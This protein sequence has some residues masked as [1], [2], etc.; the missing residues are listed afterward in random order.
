MKKIKVTLLIVLLSVCFSILSQNIVT[1]KL[2]THVY[3]LAADSLMGRKAG[4][5][6]AR[7]AADYIVAQ[8]EEIGISPLRGGSYFMPFIEDQY[9]NLVGIIEGNHPDLKDEYIIVGAHYDHLGAQYN[10]KGEKLIFNGADDNASGT[11]VLIELGRKLK[12]M[13]PQLARSV[14]L[15]A[16][17]AEE[18]GL[19]GSNEFVKNPPIPLES[20]ILMFSLDMVGWYK[21]SGYLLYSGSR[22]I[23]NGKKLL[24]D[25]N[26]IPAGLNVRTQGF[27]K[28]P[29][30]AT[31]TYGFAA[32]SIPTLAV[33]TGLKSPYH[34]PTDVAEMIDYDGM[35]L[36]TEHL[37]NIVHAVSTSEEYVA[38]GKISSKHRM[39][40]ISF[41]ISANLGSNFHY[42]TAGALDGKSAFSYGF[43]M[44]ATLNKGI[45]GFRPE[46][47]YDFIN[48]HHPDGKMNLNG[49]TV[50][51][52]FLLQSTSSF[53]AGVAF[54]A[55][56]Y[57]GYKFYGK[58]NKKEID[59]ENIYNREEI[60]INLGFELRLTNIYLGV[61][62]RN[63]FTNFTQ[64]KNSD[65]AYI[66]NRSAFF[67]ISYI[68]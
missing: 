24:M 28:H 68:F 20:M 26:L 22:T 60:G 40:L 5:I 23:S 33:T 29:F 16:F 30:G 4:S 51:V 41:G 6:Y 63:P 18:I 42:Y 65:K 61:N 58:Q 54:F 9:N 45:F 67:T 53:P 13:Q 48:A 43:G 21:E 19:Y 46:V 31:D 52:N 44:S 8:W 1:D 35:T 47:F 62:T 57:Y 14:I 27:E 64:T 37:A 38:S 7:K 55:G 12:A 17:D 25:N 66:R 49:I 34:Q 56:P 59:F 32:K 50:P 15:I 10:N 2:R 39:P 36:I 11:A 3:T